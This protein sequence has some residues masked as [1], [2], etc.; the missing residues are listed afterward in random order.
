M[1]SVK[2]LVD[3]KQWKSVVDFTLSAWSHVRS[4]PQWDNVQHNSV[5]KH[6]FKILSTSCLTSLKNVD[7]DVDWKLRVKERLFFKTFSISSLV[8]RT[9]ICRLESLQDDAEGELALCINYLN[10]SLTSS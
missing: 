1:E 7:D 4:T 6:C 5:K 3:S 2:Q 10:T 8:I 9:F